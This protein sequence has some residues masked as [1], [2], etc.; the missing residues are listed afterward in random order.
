ML[1]EILSDSKKNLYENL[2]VPENKVDGGWH[3]FNI[4]FIS[5]ASVKEFFLIQKFI[6]EKFNFKCSLMS[7][8]YYWGDYYTEVY[9]A[10]WLSPHP[11]N[12]NEFADYLFKKS[13]KSQ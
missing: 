7:A 1:T 8:E 3:N 9:Y 2:V 11:D 12:F 4:G 10:S 6:N 13:S 5:E